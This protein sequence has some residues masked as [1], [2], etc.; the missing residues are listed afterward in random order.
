[1][2][3]P[4]QYW[5]DG[6]KRIA[7]LFD[8]KRIPCSG[9]SADMKGDVL[10]DNFF[11]EVK[12]RGQGQI[13]VVGWYNLARDQCANQKREQDRKKKVLLVVHEKRLKRD[14][15][16]LDIKD[17]IELLGGEA[18][19]EQPLPPLKP[20]TEDECVEGLSKLFGD[21]QI[22]KVFGQRGAKL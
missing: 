14:L 12:N 1:M 8:G 9:S 7:M 6:E 20:L 21:E 5:K 13:S 4:S 16:V 19:E 11:I 10:H 15:V 18:I 3:Q 2:G 22:D 17:F